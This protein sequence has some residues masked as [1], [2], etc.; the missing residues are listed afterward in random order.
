VACTRDAGGRDTTIKG[1]LCDSLVCGDAQAALP[2]LEAQQNAGEESLIALHL[3]WSAVFQR[4]EKYLLW[5]QGT[6]FR[7]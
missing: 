3:S 2:I 6:I 4:S 7:E 5:F 1:R